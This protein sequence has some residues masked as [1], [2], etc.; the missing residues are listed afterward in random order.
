MT[1]YPIAHGSSGFATGHV[2]RLDD[3]RHKPS[4]AD[5]FIVWFRFWLTVWGMR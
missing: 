3:Y 5:A 1:R 4:L 2:V